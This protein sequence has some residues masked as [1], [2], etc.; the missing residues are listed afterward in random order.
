LEKSRRDDLR[1]W[2][3]CSEDCH[4]VQGSYALKFLN[5]HFSPDD[6]SDLL[7]YKKHSSVTAWFSAH[8]GANSSLKPGEGLISLDTAGEEGT[9][10]EAA[11][12]EDEQ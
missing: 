8:R 7:P 6:F 11:E 12:R 3:R 10:S 5:K 9:L 1:H 4:G 2:L